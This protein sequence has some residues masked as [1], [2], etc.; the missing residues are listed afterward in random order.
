MINKN[1]KNIKILTIVF[2]LIYN[3]AWGQSPY[4]WSGKRM[5]KLRIDSISFLINH[6]SID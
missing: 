2:I 1:N 6:K 4:Y 5:I 3:L